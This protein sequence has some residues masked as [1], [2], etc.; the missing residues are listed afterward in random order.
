MRCRSGTCRAIGNHAEYS[1]YATRVAIAGGN[2]DP[3]LLSGMRG[4]IAAL[5]DACDCGN[6]E[7]E[8]T[9]IPIYSKGRC[10]TRP[11][12]WIA[13]SRL[14]ICS[15]GCRTPLK[16]ISTSPRPS[17]GRDP[18]ST[19]STLAILFRSTRVDRNLELARPLPA[20]MKTAHR[21]GLEPAM[22]IGCSHYQFP[23]AARGPQPCLAFYDGHVDLFLAL[24]NRLRGAFHQ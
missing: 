17:P 15:L 13:A 7:R 21:T 8:S 11:Q 16:A 20:T 9:A 19:L 18:A 24:V 22:P 1:R 6:P 2:M 5:H 4:R 14:Q 10:P 3:C 23:Y 12:T